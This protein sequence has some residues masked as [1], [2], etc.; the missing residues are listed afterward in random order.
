MPWGNGTAVRLTE[1]KHRALRVRIQGVGLNDIVPAGRVA[2]GRM[3][4]KGRHVM[5]AITIGVFCLLAADTAAL[6]Q[7]LPPP[8]RTVFKCEA[9]GKVVYSDSPCLGATK[10]DVEPTRG[11]NA[12]TGKGRT[13]PDVQHE[14]TREQF[15]EAIRPITGMDAK[16]LD[17]AGRRTK[18]TADGQAQCKTLDTQI[19]ASEADEAK[20]TGANRQEVQVRLLR[21]RQQFRDLRC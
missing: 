4:E 5:R 13:G 7:S 14:R 1:P 19:P 20:S 11:A 18:L 10:V 17:T 6:A 3:S 2:R 15:A 9:A 21:L 16:Q 12:I 8:S